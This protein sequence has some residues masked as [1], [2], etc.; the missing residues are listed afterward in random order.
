MCIF[1]GPVNSVDCTKIFARRGSGSKQCLV[2]SMNVDAPNDVAMVLP[3]PVS[4]Q[5]DSAVSFVALDHYPEFFEDMDNGF[6]RMRSKSLCAAELEVHQVGNFVASF[7][8]RAK[9][10]VRLSPAFR[11]PDSVLD[12]LTEYGNFGFAV[13]QL[14]PGNQQ[15]HPMAMWFPTKLNTLYFPTKHVHDG[16]TVEDMAHFDHKLYFQSGDPHQITK[17]SGNAENFMK[18]TRGLVS[19]GQPCYR[20]KLL[21]NLMNRDTYV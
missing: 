6:P 5:T 20:M 4:E 12:H 2:Y 17:T 13:F 8:P 19:P 16:A 11:L 7:V 14:K 9:D 15:V 10:F 21:G 18:D 1:S 3:L